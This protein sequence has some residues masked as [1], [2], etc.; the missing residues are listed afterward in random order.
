MKVLTSGGRLRCSGTIALVALVALVASLCAQQQIFVI[1][2][3]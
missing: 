2:P 3:S 1:W